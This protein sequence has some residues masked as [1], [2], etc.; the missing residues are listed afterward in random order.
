MKISL[1]WLNDYIDVK[2][3]WNKPDQLV[4]LL[5]SAGLEVESVQDL[6][7]QFNNVVIGHILEKGQHPGADKLT[8]CQVS[9]GNGVV[10][11]IVCGAKNHNAG[12][13]VVV[14][15]PG[16]VLPGDFAIKISAIRGVESR[17]MLC[18][19]EELGLRKAEDGP[20]PGILI[21]PKDAPIGENFAKYKKLDDLVFEVKVTPNR[22]DCLSHFGLAREIAAIKGVDYE[23]PMKSLSE[24][25]A[26]SKDMIGLTVKETTLC[27]RYAGRG[28]RG[29]KVSSSPDWMKARLEA[30]GVKSIN[31][32]VDITNYVM[33]ELGQ[34]LHAF[35]VRFLDG[36]KIIV[37]KSKAGEA[38]TT[39]D[40]TELILSGQEL[41]IR[42][43]A[44]PVALAGVVGGKN[45]G[46]QSDT[47]DVFVESAY[48]T[49]ASVRRSSRQFGI[50]TESGYRFA[51]GVNPDACMLAL[52]RACELIQTLCGGE[53]LG[54]PHDAY[55]KPILRESVAVDVGLVA[56]RLGYPVEKSAFVNWMKRIGCKVEEGAGTSLNITPPL[57]RWD[58]NIDMDFI[59]EYSRL[60]GYERIP[61]KFPAIVSEPTHDHAEQKALNRV[62]EAMLR[63][64]Y[65][66]AVNYNFVS[67]KKQTAFLGRAKEENVLVKNPISD[68]LDT[69]RQCLSF[70]LFQNLLHNYRYGNQAG[71]L[72]ETG[73]IFK[74]SKGEYR[75]ILKLSAISWGQDLD[76]WRKP[77]S[78]SVLFNLKGDFEEFFELVQEVSFADLK[79]TPEFLHP[80]QSTGIYLDQNLIGYLGSLHP[81][82]LEQ[83][84]IRTDVAILEVDLEKLMALRTENKRVLTPPRVPAV[85]RD[86]AFVLT[87]SVTAGQVLQ[88]IEVAAGDLLKRVWVYDEF[89]GAP[90]KDGERSLTFR[91]LLQDPNETLTDDVLMKLQAKIIAHAKEKL[92]V[93]IR[94]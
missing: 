59:E 33:M 53:V 24:S 78:H 15:L 48:F 10:H 11:Q 73:K 93:S 22:A 65:R 90:L 25:S 21:L 91:M 94:S 72:F 37:E 76:L 5:T 92:S 19:E 16:A 6:G 3:Y 44:K 36:K 31:N 54:D 64:G 61:E 86:L 9:T 84:K 77:I 49:Q 34:P 2:E 63:L 1:N 35:D 74:T 47:T 39:L 67:S 8:L 23:F 82:I 29:V 69:M 32:I 87:E 51:R 50:E 58:I 66:Q 45:S 83:E 68:D 18:S 81:M 14:A 41:M 43:G 7:K 79:S 42:D 13:R 27:P 89:K 56:Q 80:G 60:D 75:E 12:D 57:F 26:S 28:V 46:V 17:G 88:E 71:Q 55:P 52:N 30:V 40:G 85:E 20:S 38:F 70:G 62:H 4:G